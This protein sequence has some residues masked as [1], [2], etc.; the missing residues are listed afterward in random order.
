MNIT[1]RNP[2]NHH[3]HAAKSPGLSL[4]DPRLFRRPWHTLEAVP[5]VLF[6]DQ[7]L[8][9][10]IPMRK[11]QNDLVYIHHLSCIVGPPAHHWY[12]A[13]SSGLSIQYRSSRAR[14]TALER[15]R[16]GHLQGVC[17]VLLVADP[18]QVVLQH[19]NF[20]TFQSIT[21]LAHLDTKSEFN[22]A[23]SPTFRY[24]SMELPL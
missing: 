3:W 13:K 12:A 21:K 11:K 5:Y 14:Q 16:S 19:I 8:A 22:L 9:C 18:H 10:G 2:P 20:C 1:W 24:V 6:G 4:R 23:L 17:A 15:L 7:N